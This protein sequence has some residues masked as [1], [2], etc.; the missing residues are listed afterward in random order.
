MA[1]ESWRW[2]PAPP[3]VGMLDGGSEVSS[4]LPG[5]ALY[6]PGSAKGGLLAYKRQNR[7]LKGE[8]VTPNYANSTESSVSVFVG[9]QCIPL[10]IFSWFARGAV[11]RLQ[12]NGSRGPSASFTGRG[13]GGGVYAVPRAHPTSWLPLLPRMVRNGWRRP[14][15][16]RVNSGGVRRLEGSSGEWARSGS[17]KSLARLERLGGG[18]LC[19]STVNREPGTAWQRPSVSQ[20]WFQEGTPLARAPAALR[21]LRRPWCRHSHARP[22]RMNRSSRPHGHLGALLYHHSRRTHRPLPTRHNTVSSASSWRE[23]VEGGGRPAAATAACGIASAGPVGVW[24]RHRG[25][26][27]LEHSHCDEG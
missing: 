16:A 5:A 10:I 24:G 1:T 23:G 2:R 19:R 7:A 6:L 4:D 14:M 17:L 11:C 22:R 20:G 21:A 25:P 15:T 13:P 26:R 3:L 27:G 9:T 8:C 18:P 12:S